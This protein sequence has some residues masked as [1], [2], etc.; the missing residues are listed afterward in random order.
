MR[1]DMDFKDY[2]YIQ[3]NKKCEFIDRCKFA[4]CVGRDESRQTIH[5]CATRRAYLCLYLDQ[6]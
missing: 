3:P 1:E 2:M 6:K 4:P 5:S